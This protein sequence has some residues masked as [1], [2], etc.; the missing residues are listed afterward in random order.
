V[1]SISQQLKMR[2]DPRRMRVATGLPP[3]GVDAAEPGPFAD[4][5]LGL[6]A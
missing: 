2:N 4:R 6:A 1:L 3:L 5:E